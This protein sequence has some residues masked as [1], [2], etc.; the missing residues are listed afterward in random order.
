MGFGGG[1]FLDAKHRPQLAYTFF[2]KTVVQ[3]GILISGGRRRLLS[4]GLRKHEWG[5]CLLY[6]VLLKETLK[7]LHVILAEDSDTLGWWP[8]KRKM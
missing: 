2:G 6:F 1:P 8:L 4:L 5:R 3:K 7:F